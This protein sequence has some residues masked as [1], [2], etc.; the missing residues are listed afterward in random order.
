MVER[1]FGL[2]V[3]RQV[4]P[5]GLDALSPGPILAGFL[6]RID[7][8]RNGMALYGHRS[9]QRTSTPDRNHQPKTHRRSETDSPNPTSDTC[10]SRMSNAVSRLRHR[11]PG[12][13]NRRRTHHPLQPCPPLPPPP[14]GKTPS[15]LETNPHTRRQPHLAQR[16][17]PHLHHQRPI[18]ITADALPARVTIVK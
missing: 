13:R 3:E 9:R 5:G 2:V 18:A 6:F 10:L 12:S 4:L 8:S 17:R 16:T 11:P 1:M 15:T 7:R 14:P